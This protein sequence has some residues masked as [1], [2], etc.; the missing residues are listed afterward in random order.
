M[1]AKRL[2]VSSQLL[3][4]IERG[5]SDPRFSLMKKISSL[6]QE[7][8]EKLWPPEVEEDESNEDDE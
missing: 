6:Y 3:S 1:A 7:P 2:G 5:L 8:I 4:Q